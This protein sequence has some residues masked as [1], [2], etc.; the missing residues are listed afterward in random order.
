MLIKF[1]SL[2]ILLLGIL[3][4]Y[5]GVTASNSIYPKS[6]HIAILR[7]GATFLRCILGKMIQN[8]FTVKFNFNCKFNDL[9]EEMGGMTTISIELPNLFDLTGIFSYKKINELNDYR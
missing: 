4:S 3:S 2:P 9:G 7:I 5:K 6:K 8:N 1:V